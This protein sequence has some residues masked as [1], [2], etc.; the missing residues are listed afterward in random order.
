MRWPL[1]I[2]EPQ[3][4]YELAD[5]AT[6]ARAD[7]SDFILDGEKTLVLDGDSAGS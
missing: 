1:R 3:S 2:A 4:R 7:G 5:V 6:S